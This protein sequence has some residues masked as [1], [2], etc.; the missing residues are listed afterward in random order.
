MDGIVVEGT[1]LERLAEGLYRAELPN[2]HKIFAHFSQKMSGEAI[3][4]LP[5]SKVLVEISPYDLSRGRITQPLK[6]QKTGQRS[7]SEPASEDVPSEK[8]GRETE[9]GDE[10]ADEVEVKVVKGVALEKGVSFS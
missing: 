8:E 3:P 7:T 6:Y 5:G 4:I 1:V 2:G 9:T 10:I